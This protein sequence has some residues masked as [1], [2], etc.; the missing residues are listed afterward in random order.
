MKIR[1][2]MLT[3]IVAVAWGGLGYAQSDSK[4]LLAY[5]YDVDN[6]GYY[7]PALCLPLSGSTAGVCGGPGRQE[8]RK[9][10]T[11]GAASTTVT[12]VDTNA[13][14]SAVL[15]GDIIQ[16]NVPKSTTTSALETVQYLRRVATK[17]DSSTI[18]V[19]SAV[20]IPAAG[21]GFT[22]WKATDTAAATSLTTGAGWWPFPKTGEG[23]TVVIDFNTVSLTG[24][25]DY[26]LECRHKFWDK[27]L[28]PVIMAGPTNVTTAGVARIDI[29]G[30]SYD[31]CRTCFKVGTSDVDAVTFT[32][33]IRDIDFVE[34]ADSF[35]V[36]ASDD[37]DFTEDPGGVPKVCTASISH[38][39]RTGA[40]TCT[41]LAN[42]MNSAACTPDNTYSCTFS[43]STH[44]FTIAR[45]TGTKA[46]S[47][48][49]QTGANTATS[50]KTL[51]GFANLDDTGGT[52]YVSDTAAGGTTFNAQM[53]AGGYSP[54]AACIEVA[55]KLNATASIHGAY[56]CAY[57]SVTDK[58]TI[59]ATGID[60]LQL[61]W[62]TGTNNATAADSA[63]GFS[64]DVTGAL[65][66]T[67][68][69][70]ALTTGVEKVNISVERHPG[71]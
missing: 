14:F 54:A 28:A 40:A 31:E 71:E 70:L 69:A 9:I 63:L 12:G 4:S 65:T 52:S 55:A 26:K 34:Y 45:A 19:D 23:T 22:W 33:G 24:G 29:Y 30:E 46:V 44:K 50:L 27:A 10:T 37:I 47:L 43:N 2:A 7:C 60:E 8:T 18:T 32:A 56:T 67:G 61:L 1:T 35:T 53:T 62:N 5:D 6:T 13:A 17:T 11:S 36:G 39:Q 25:I 20:T 51:L 3:L 66:Y 68:A 42:A 48:L 41:V 57:D 59:T 58:I 16:I 49:W 21:V 15:P 38:L 64:A